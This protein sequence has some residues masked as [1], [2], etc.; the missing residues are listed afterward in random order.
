MLTS[1]K[2]RPSIAQVGQQRKKICHSQ[3]SAL[4]IPNLPSI[5]VLKNSNLF[6]ELSKMNN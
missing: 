2:S 4:T 3:K 1:T 6:V 5:W